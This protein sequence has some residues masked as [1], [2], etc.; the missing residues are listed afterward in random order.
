[1]GTAVD[2]VR[3]GS[4]DGLRDRCKEEVGQREVDEAFAERSRQGALLVVSTFLAVVD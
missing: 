3:L 1:M 2:S 4:Q